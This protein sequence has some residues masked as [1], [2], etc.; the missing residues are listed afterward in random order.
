MAESNRVNPFGEIVSIDQR[1]LFIGNRGCIHRDHTIVRPWKV[2][3]W[4]VCALEH[5]SWLAPKWQPNRWTALFFW[6]EAVAFAAG[7]RPCS[8]C[9]HTD[10]VRWMDA[11]QLATG[12]RP[13]VDRLDE[14]MHADRVGLGKLQRCHE[15]TWADLPLGSFVAVDDQPMLVLDDRLVPWRPSAAGYG[16]SVARPIS[17]Q[18]TVLTLRSTVEV[19]RHGYKPVIH[20]S[21]FDAG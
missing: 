14:V 3:R 10:F 4:I 18:A 16:P 20:P 12:E 21:A 19:L 6:D 9:R 1:G 7:H 17:G 15:A 8:M 11:W 5:N 13:K 2:Q